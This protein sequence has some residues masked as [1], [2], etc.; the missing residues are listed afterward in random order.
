[1][2]EEKIRSMPREELVQTAARVAGYDMQ[3]ACFENEKE[4]MQTTL[5]GTNASLIEYLIDNIDFMNDNPDFKGVM[6]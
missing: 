3:I 6:L 5:S 4:I 1:M 2:T